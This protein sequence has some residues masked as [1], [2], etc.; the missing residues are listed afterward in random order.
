MEVQYKMAS[1]SGQQKKTAKQQKPVI[2]SVDEKV[3]CYEPD[4]TKTK[5]LY[6]AKVK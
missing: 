4:P 6:D 1:K 3:L 2:F 5:V